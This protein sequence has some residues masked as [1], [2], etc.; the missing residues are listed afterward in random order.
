MGALRQLPSSNGATTDAAPVQ[1]QQVMYASLEDINSR[2]EIYKGRHSIVWNAACGRTR[3]PIILKGY[4][5]AKMTERNFHQVRREIRLMQQINYDGAVKLLGHFEDST[6]IYL[7]QEM[8]AKGDLFKR[9]IRSGGMLDEKFVA[10]EVLLPMLL[11]L[12]HL[13]ARSIYHRDI[14]PEN[15]FFTREGKFKLGDFGLAIDASLERSKSRVGTLD[16][17]SPEV[18]SLPTADERKKLEVAGRQLVEQPYG[19]KCDIWACGVLAYEL[20]VGKPPFEVK[21]EMETRKRIMYETTLT[22]PPHVSPEAVNFIKTALAKNAGMRPAAADLVHHAWLRPYLL[23]MAAASGQLDAATLSAYKNPPSLAA[24]SSVAAAAAVGSHGNSNASS[25]A[26]AAAQSNTG[27]FACTA[28]VGR[29]ASF[30]GV[31][32]QGINSMPGH[33]QVNAVDAAAAA[34]AA[35]AGPEKLGRHNLSHLSVVLSHH[36]RGSASP[37]M[38]TTP[39]PYGAP[40]MSRKPV[41]DSENGGHPSR[42]CAQLACLGRFR[43]PPQAHAPSPVACPP[44]AATHCSR[45]H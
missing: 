9:L 37:T 12:E 11:T 5:K 13:H 17:M 31:I 6:T 38:P 33:G 43:A 18:V 39:G 29:S 44:A 25:N 15:I 4:V 20:L 21:D 2:V 40:G 23:A 16:Y 27:L 45:Q 3:K 34:A 42:Q 14:K 22:L 1:P 30:T 24:S 41:W 19:E 32:R 36:T 10:G 35:V 26:S 7:V 28:G 8:C